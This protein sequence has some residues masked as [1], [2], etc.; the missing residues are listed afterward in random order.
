MRGGFDWYTGKPLLVD[1][2]KPPILYDQSPASNLS[3]APVSLFVSYSNLTVTS[4]ILTRQLD[5]S[6]EG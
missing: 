6:K 3:W 2:K 1:V 5:I 4:H